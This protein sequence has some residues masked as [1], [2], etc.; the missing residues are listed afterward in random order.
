MNSGSAKVKL[1]NKWKW[2]SYQGWWWNSV[3]A[4]WWLSLAWPVSFNVKETFGIIQLQLSSFFLLCFV[5]FLH[6][7][8]HVCVRACTCVCVRCDLVWVAHVSNTVMETW[9]VF[10]EPKKRVFRISR[11]VRQKPFRSGSVLNQQLLNL[12]GFLFC[13]LTKQRTTGLLIPRWYLMEVL[14]VLIVI[15]IINEQCHLRWTSRTTYSKKWFKKI[16]F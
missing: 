14:M 9:L 12:S 13:L 3:C 7:C 4:C 1:H 15:G 2:G 16:F 6:A 5:L 11:A 8:V 10:L